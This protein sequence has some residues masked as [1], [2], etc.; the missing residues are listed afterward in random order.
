MKKFLFL[1][2]L[3]FTFFSANAK[4]LLGGFMNY[5][6]INKFT[7]SNNYKVT[8]TLYRDC[9]PGTTD[10]DDASSTHISAFRSDNSALA[11]Y[12]SVSIISRTTLPSP[13]II[14]FSNICIEKIIY[15]GTVTLPNSPAGYDI[16][17]MRCCRSVAISNLTNPGS[18]GF[19]LST[20]IPPNSMD[21]SAPQIAGEWA[22][23]LCAA[24]PYNYDLSATDADGDSIAYALTNP[25]TGG[26]PAQPQPFAVPPPFDTIQFLAPF[27]L[28]NLI[29]T[30][31]TMFY[32]PNGIMTIN[33]YNIGNYSVGVTL[34]EYRNHVLIAQHHSELSL[35]VIACLIADIQDGSSTEAKIYPN[36][37]EDILHI[38]TSKEILSAEIWNMSGQLM[39]ISPEKETNIDVTAMQSGIYLLKVSTKEGTYWQRWE[40]K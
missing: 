20:H 38:Q 1:C 17:W 26:D 36:P 39:L 6:L 28:T 9:L 34:S 14:S 30:N 11:A 12:L 8:L 40:K 32:N 7:S 37:V 10:F 2:L 35:L 3:C 27:S 33:P 15:E 5:E 18:V 19:A 25:W 16:T 4:H 22:I 23:G 21:N 13:A 29:G 24:T 31:S